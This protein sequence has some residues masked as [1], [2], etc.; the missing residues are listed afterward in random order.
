MIFSTLKIA[1]HHLQKKHTIEQYCIFSSKMN[2]SDGAAPSRR[3]A[4]DTDRYSFRDIDRCDYSISKAIAQTKRSASP[5][6]K[7]KTHN[8]YVRKGN[9]K[10]ASSSATTAVGEFGAA[11]S[12]STS[13]A[14][15]SLEITAM[16]SA[17]K[18]Q[19]RFSNVLVIFTF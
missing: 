6:V 19:K 10:S 17:G 3:S 7:K 8:K 5:I 9:A 15:N 4:R 13:G 1:G 14:N 2:S 11:S 16:S 12:T 18:K